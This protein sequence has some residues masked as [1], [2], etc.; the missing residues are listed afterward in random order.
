[1][2]WGLRDF[3]TRSS[4]SVP[5]SRLLVV[6]EGIVSLDGADLYRELKIM[7]GDIVNEP[8]QWGSIVVRPTSFAI[9]GY[10]LQLNIE[11]IARN[12]PRV[13]CLFSCTLNYNAVWFKQ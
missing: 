10:Y 13:P 3:N 1:V 11:N 6:V 4:M 7:Y 12:D 5:Y 2:F 8:V 9:H